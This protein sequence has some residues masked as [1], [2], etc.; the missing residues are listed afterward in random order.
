MTKVAVKFYIERE[1]PFANIIKTV[2]MSYNEYLDEYK[3]WNNVV[4]VANTS[5]ET[6]SVMIEYITHDLRL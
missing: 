1:K 6:G 5:N 3:D 2:V 4:S